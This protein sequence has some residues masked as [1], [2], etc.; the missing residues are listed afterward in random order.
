MWS[1]ETIN[2]LN[3][4]A[5]KKARKRG[6]SPFVPAGPE[7][8]ENWPPFPFPNLGDFNPPGWEQTQSWFV[9]KTGLGERWEP[10][11]TWQQLKNELQEYIAENP[12]HGFAITEEGQF[13]LY[14][15]AFRPVEDG[16]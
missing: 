16:R 14:I 5:G 3:R 2:Y 11:L 13:Q 10:A 1:L 15:T 4:Q 9:D 6:K 8:V 12:G 7:N